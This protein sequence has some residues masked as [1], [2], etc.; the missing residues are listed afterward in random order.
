MLNRLTPDSLT[1]IASYVAVIE[2][3]I[4]VMQKASTSTSLPRWDD[5]LFRTQ[6]FLRRFELFF[7][8]QLFLGRGSNP[9]LSC[10]YMYL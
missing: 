9:W 10:R 6:A 5:D 3:H 2:L 1:I 8:L 4:G 7:G